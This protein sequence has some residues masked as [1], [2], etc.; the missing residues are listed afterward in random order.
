MLLGRGLRTFEPLASQSGKVPSFR[1]RSMGNPLLEGQLEYITVLDH[2]SGN[3]LVLLY[4][5]LGDRRY[6]PIP[7]VVPLK[8]SPLRRPACF[9]PLQ[10]RCPL[11]PS[12]RVQAII[13]H[14]SGVPGMLCS[15]RPTETDV[16]NRKQKR[17]IN[18]QGTVADFL[19]EYVK[20]SSHQTTVAV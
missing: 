4:R 7:S 9:N 20:L 15:R 1:F 2:L 18:G 6:P 10:S 8:P 16:E 11:N 14:S 19:A 17:T 13:K 5:P 12:I 3:V